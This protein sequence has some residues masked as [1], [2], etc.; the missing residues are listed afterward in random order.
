M[1]DEEKRF[2]TPREAWQAAGSILTPEQFI[3]E[4]GPCENLKLFIPEIQVPEYLLEP[5]QA[6]QIKDALDSIL[7]IIGPWGEKRSKIFT[8]E[9]IKAATTF[10]EL[11]GLDPL[12]IIDLASIRF[13]RLANLH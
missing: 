12:E 6:T 11:T 10:Q 5:G 7:K 8:P 3:T 1:A 13:H 9:Y 4:P 2:L